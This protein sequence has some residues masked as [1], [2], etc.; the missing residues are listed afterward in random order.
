MDDCN[1][2]YGGLKR[3]KTEPE[4]R[5]E[6]IVKELNA[7][8]D[9]IS[10]L[11]D[12]LYCYL[13]PEKSDCIAMKNTSSGKIAAKIEPAPIVTSMGKVLEGI[14]TCWRTIENM[15]GRLEV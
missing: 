13:R 9:T 5:M 15:R 8:Q 14:K 2:C 10:L 4:I 7:L 11:K 12:G 1:V 3:K 6:E